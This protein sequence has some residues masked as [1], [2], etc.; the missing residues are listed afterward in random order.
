MTAVLLALLLTFS[1]PTEL[2]RT[3]PDNPFTG[4]NAPIGIADQCW[5]VLPTG[6][7]IWL[8]ETASGIVVHFE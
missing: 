4:C 6:G 3:I 2:H 7:T 8:T 5:I 1:H